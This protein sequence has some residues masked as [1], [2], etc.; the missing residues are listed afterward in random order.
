DWVV[1]D[2]LGEALRCEQA[3]VPTLTVKRGN[4]FTPDWGPRPWG[5]EPDTWAEM[6]GNAVSFI[7][8]C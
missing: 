6:T 1:Y 2:I 3:F 7:D 4:L 8:C 5:W